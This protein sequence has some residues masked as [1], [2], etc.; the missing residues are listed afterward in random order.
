MS[1]P[2]A[3]RRDFLKTST[4]AAAATALPVAAG[5]SRTAQADDNRKL[6]TA[7]I[8]VGNMGLS[9]LK[10]IM[11]HP[12][13]N[14]VALC[15]I[16]AD[17]LAKAAELHPQARQFTDFRKMLEEM[18][19]EIDAVVVSTPDH[20]HA[21]AAMSAM[22]INKP[23]YCQKPLTH[24][25]YE[26]RQLRL[27]AEK[28]KLATQMGT[29]I[30]SHQVYR[31][32][33]AMIQAGAIGKVKHVYA[34][35]AG[36]WG[37]EG[38]PFENTE[39]PPKSV[40]WDEWLGT[41]EFRPYVPKVYHPFEWRRLIDF[42]TGTLGD[43]GVHIFDTP[44]GALELT[45][46]KWTQVEC[47][48]PTGPGHPN[49]MVVNYEFPGTKYTTENLK[50]TWMD[51][52]KAPPK[53]EDVGLPAGVKLPGA[54]SISVGTEGVLLLPHYSEAILFPEEKFKDYKR[55]EIGSNNHYHEWVDACLGKGET[56]CPFSYGGPLTE[57]LLLG[58][59]ASNFPGQKLYWDA[60]KLEVTNIPEANKFLRRKYR[61]GY[62]VAGL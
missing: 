29:Q 7:H 46:P 40:R 27:A 47:R 12:Q 42:G 24:D 57:A 18:G 11:S 36:G 62:E 58:I 44:Y 19:D 1:P 51:G 43:L 6:R 53:S 49:E 54:G 3:S 45:A 30:H 32:A 10:S 39:T 4:L 55:P 25:V 37:Y 5:A 31:R 38:G 17:F 50:W 28:K 59:V 33:V 20:T 14:V 35:R 22:N 13:V 52:K 48:K 2:H 60:E 15:D 16:D 21:P 61:E 23:V 26:A 34:W 56:S 41:A 9:D 8:G